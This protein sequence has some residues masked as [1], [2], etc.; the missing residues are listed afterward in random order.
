MITKILMV[1]DE[2]D[3]VYLLQIELEKDK[4]GKWDGKFPVT[5]MGSSMPNTLLQVPLP[6]PAVKSSK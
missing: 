1:D 2:K 5:Y 3:M 4:L 6:V